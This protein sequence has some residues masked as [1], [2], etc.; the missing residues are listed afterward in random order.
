VRRAAK[1]DANENDLVGYAEQLGLMWVQT[2]PLDGWALWREHW[3]PV[4]IKNVDGKNKYTDAQVL[5]LA[6]CK[7]RNAPVWTWRTLDDVM[8][9]LNCRIAA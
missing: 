4:E 7:E 8:K 5:F 2:G 3:Y 1:R 6:R 9:S